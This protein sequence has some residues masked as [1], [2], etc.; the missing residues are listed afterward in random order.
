VP[1]VAGS[2]DTSLFVVEEGRTGARH[3][4]AAKRR[5]EN[6]QVRVLG[7][8]V[9]RSQVR[10]SRMSEVAR[11]GKG[12]GRAVAGWRRLVGIET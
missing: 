3:A 12:P 1:V 2:A 4:L 9:N 7:L 5:L 11:N 10:R 8:V 6:H